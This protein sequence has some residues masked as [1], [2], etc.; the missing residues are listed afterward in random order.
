MNE[1]TTVL[2]DY[3]LASL[4][5]VLAWRLSRSSS[6]PTAP[7]ALWGASFLVLAIAALVGGT[8]HGIPPDAA[9]ALRR[10]LWSF[11]YVAIGLADLFTLA[12]ATLVALA[13]GRRLVVLALL[14][15]RFLVSVALILERRDFRDVAFEYAVTLL[16]LLAFGVDLARRG[17]RSARFVLGGVLVSFAGGLA[18]SLR[19]DLH[20][21][22][23]HNDLFH[24][25][26]MA[27]LWLL[28]RAG[29]LLRGRRDASR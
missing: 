9:P 28:F 25:V 11:T 20:P 14:T 13:G 4:A 8:W 26:Q 27:G 18:Q 23:N 22:F 2:T 16:L 10:L 17:E 6:H 3:L 7:R 24:L 29:L 12:G 1:P 21:R 19:L 15:G 5:L